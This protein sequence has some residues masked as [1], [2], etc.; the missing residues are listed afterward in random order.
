MRDKPAPNAAVRRAQLMA[1]KDP[2]EHQV[3]ALGAELLRGE[4]HGRRHGRDPV[5]PVEH[6][7]QRQAVEREIG[8]RQEQ[9]RQAAQA[10]IPEQQLAIVV[11][12]GQPA[13]GDG[14]DEIEDAHRREQAGGLH[15]RNAEIEAHRDQMHLDQAVGA[16]RRR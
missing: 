4:P 8:E 3:G 9:Q 1:G 6:R 10:V 13:G 2:A 7:E 11:A 15:L 16:E 5:E 14:A 12:V